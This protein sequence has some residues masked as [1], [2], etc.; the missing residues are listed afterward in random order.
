MEVSS[1]SY[2]FGELEI[3]ELRNLPATYKWV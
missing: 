3:K 1:E 2:I